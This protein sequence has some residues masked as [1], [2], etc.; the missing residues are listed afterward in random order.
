MNRQRKINC[1]T[2]TERER[3]IERAGGGGE[4]GEDQIVEG[5]SK[6]EWRRSKMTKDVCSSILC[7]SLVIKPFFSESFIF[8]KIT[9]N[10]EHI[11]NLSPILCFLVYL[12]FPRGNSSYHANYRE[13][14]LLLP[15]LMVVR[16]CDG[17]FLLNSSSTLIGVKPKVNR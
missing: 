17:L 5:R 13:A 3:E 9:S 6:K 2:F 12:P 15:R 1:M 14:G 11:L 4:K 7:S 8:F 16:R 10:H